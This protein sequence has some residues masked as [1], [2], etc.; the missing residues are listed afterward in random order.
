MQHYR[1]FLS[2]VRQSVLRDGMSR[3]RMRGPS[4]RMRLL[5]LLIE[6]VMKG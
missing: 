6:E 4:F 3:N 5:I 1:L 2:S